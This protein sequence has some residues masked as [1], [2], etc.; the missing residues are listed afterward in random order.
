LDYV[1]VGILAFGFCHSWDFGML[2][3]CHSWDFGILDLGLWQFGFWEF[4]FQ[5]KPFVINS[6]VMTFTSTNFQ[7]KLYIKYLH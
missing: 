3:F 7:Q 4:G 1:I 2:G 5:G 6:L